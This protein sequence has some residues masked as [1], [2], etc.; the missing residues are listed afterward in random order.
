MANPTPVPSNVPKPLNVQPNGHTSSNGQ[1]PAAG[2][3]RIKTEPGSEYTQVPQYTGYQP[4]MNYDTKD[5]QQ[6][7]ATL[8]AQRFGPDAELQVNKLTA[9]S[10]SPHP[11]QRPS[12]GPGNIQLPPQL[13]EQQRREY[14]ERQRQQQAR[15]MQQAQQAQQRPTVSNGQTDGADEWNE[16]VAQ[17]RAAALANPGAVREADVTLRDRLEQMS[18]SMEGGG[19]M[20]PL[21]ERPKQAQP[22]KRK[23]AVQAAVNAS[24][25]ASAAAQ[26]DDQETLRKIPQLDGFGDSDEEDK[27]GIKPESDLED[28]E[29]A[30]N[31]DLDDPDDNVIAGDDED[32]EETGQIMVCTYD[33]VA[34]VKNK[35]KCTLKD[36]ILTTGGKE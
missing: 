36:G 13:S 28:D 6:R 9:Q 26:T 17:R 10:N 3:V 25:S 20:M 30:I 1:T 27:T 32:D 31:S 14:A 21:S 7:A 35:W 18:S 8:L 2:N 19:F 22:K 34:R 5:S 15:Q 33:K 29:D 11:V 16:M 24:Q 23:A 4:N 12:A